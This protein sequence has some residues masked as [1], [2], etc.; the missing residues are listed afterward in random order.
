MNASLTKGSIEQEPQISLDQLPDKKFEYLEK[1]E[2][3]KS[4]VKQ[5][6]NNLEM[7]LQ[8]L[9]VLKF[10]GI[11]QIKSEDFYKMAVIV[12]DTGANC[13]ML[14]LNT[15]KLLKGNLNHIQPV[16]DVTIFNS[17]E[18]LSGDIILGTAWIKVGIWDS[19]SDKFIKFGEFEF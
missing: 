2:D 17:S 12:I 1:E 15:F 13:E 8:K 10:E 11:L 5:V 16:H 3:M 7:N 4:G 6:L 18:V 19:E 9:D 14:G